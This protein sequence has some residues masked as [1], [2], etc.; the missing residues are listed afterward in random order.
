MWQVLGDKIDAIPALLCA[1]FG[2][3]LIP[4]DSSQPNYNYEAIHLTIYNHYAEDG[5]EAPTLTDHPDDISRENISG[6][7]WGQ[8]VPHALKDL[9][10]NCTAY[11][12]LV[13]NLTNICLFMKENMYHHRPALAKRLDY[14]I[15]FLPR[16]EHCPFTPFGWLVVNMGGCAEAH[17]DELDLE[18]HCCVIPFT[19]NCMGGAL[20]LHEM[21][22]MLDLH[23]AD[24]IIFLSS[25]MTHYSLHF[26]GIRASFVFQMDKLMLK[27]PLGNRSNGSNGVQMEDRVNDVPTDDEEDRVSME[28]DN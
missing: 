18:N 26:Q 16:N 3:G 25:Q 10:K 15:S 9:V 21:G 5:S 11:E 8:Q 17:A 24:L 1:A 6:V 20:V 12:S 28:E 22:L 27:W 23:S 13:G 2:A 7:N 14:Y 4:T 19:K